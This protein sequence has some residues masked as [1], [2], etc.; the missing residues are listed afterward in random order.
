VPNSYWVKLWSCPNAASKRRKRRRS[1]SLNPKTAKVKEDLI[2]QD[3]SE[4]SPR[5]LQEKVFLDFPI[6]TSPPIITIGVIEATTLKRRE[7][8]KKKFSVK[9]LFIEDAAKKGAVTE[10]RCETVD[11]ADRLAA[12]LRHFV[13]SKERALIS[14]HCEGMGLI[15]EF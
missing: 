3:Q 6:A 8:M 15:G 4:F 2:C 9:C 13:G 1:L 12:S 11:E 14:V 10:V 5:F 7:M